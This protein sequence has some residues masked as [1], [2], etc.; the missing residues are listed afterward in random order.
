MEFLFNKI[1]RAVLIE[2]VNIKSENQC[3]LILEQELYN[4]DVYQSENFSLTYFYVKNNVVLFEA[5]IK[6]GHYYYFHLFLDYNMLLSNA[7]KTY[8]KEKF[9]S[10]FIDFFKLK[11]KCDCN[12]YFSGCSSFEYV[13]SNTKKIYTH[14]NVD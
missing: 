8:L 2:K 10:F 7:K 12:V 14:C 6:E 9:I 3:R 1:R 11:D 4:S 5:Q 13:V